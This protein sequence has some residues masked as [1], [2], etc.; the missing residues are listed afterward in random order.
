MASISVQNLTYRFDNGDTLFSD[1]T[2]TLDDKVTG[3]VGRNGAGKSILAALLTGDKTPYSGSVTTFCRV[4][5]LRQIGAEEK[6]VQHETISD[7]LGVRDKLE[8]LSRVA[9]GGCESHDFELIGDNWLLREELEQQ[10]LALGLPVDP[11]LPCQALSGGQLTRLALHQLFQ[12]DYGYLILDEPGNHLDE[13][14]KRWLIEQMRRF[15]GGVLII[16]HDRDILRCVDD[17]LE[18]NSLGVHHYGGA[19]DVYAEQRANELASQERRIDHAKTQ[20]KQMRQTM[21]KNREKA[22]QRAGQGK[23]VARSGS[24]AKVLLNSK[25]QD[26]ERAGGSRESNQNRQMAQAQEQLSKLNKQ[27]EMLKQQ[28][29]SLGKTEKRVSR[30]LDITEVRLP[31]IQQENDITFSVDF[32]EKIRLSGANGSGKSTL[33]K[34]I[35][36]RLS[37]VHGD[38]QVRAGLCYLDQHF[39]LLDTAK[40][41]QENLAHFCPHLSETDQRTLLAGIGLRR[42]RADQAV[43]TL[44]GGE[45][46]KVAM[47]AISHQ[48]GDT[49]LLLDEPDNHLDLDS[50]LMLAQ[51]LRDFTGSLLVV[52]HDQDFIADI[53]VS[54]EISL[55]GAA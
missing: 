39:T 20:I 30:I 35:A 1:L 13:Q 4:G 48:P 2:F 41:A 40:S 44:S 16:S 50:R 54:G 25:K 37:P 10:L 53:G 47:L 23:Q 55:D 33:L 14:G 3:L 36:G 45:K 6:L 24:Q 21:Q 32:G 8:A 15:H 5:W 18:L 17:I 43:A 49:L 9:E 22:Q 28:S 11:F 12:S 51:A 38:I 46:M 34:A 29:L 52:S 27:H 31:Y 42:E 19:Y 7:F 26:A